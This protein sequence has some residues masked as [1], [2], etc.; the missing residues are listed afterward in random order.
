MRR[1]EERASWPETLHAVFDANGY[2]VGA[3]DT[4][5]K[6]ERRVSEECV[7]RGDRGPY[8]VIEFHKRNIGC[9][10]SS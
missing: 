8:R 7:E 9:V 5:E 2:L 1:Q 10:T 4:L 6:A 3:Y